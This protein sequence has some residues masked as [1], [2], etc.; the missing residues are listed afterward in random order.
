M[1]MLDYQDKAATTAVYREKTGARTEKALTYALIG[2]AN[3]AGEACGKLKKVMRGDRPLEDA[4][5]DIGAELGDVL[6]YLAM[7]CDELGLELNDVAAA[8]LQ[9]LRGRAK[10]GSIRGDGDKR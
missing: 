2:L 1:N 9:K 8:N 6:W 3:E 4:I 7:A 10:A 5:E